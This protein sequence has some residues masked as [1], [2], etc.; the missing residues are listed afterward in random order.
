MPLINKIKD[1]KK[2]Y[3]WSKRASYFIYI[4]LFIVIGSIWFEGFESIATYLGFVSAAIAFALKD[5]IANVAGWMFIT[6]RAPFKIG[7]R[8]ELEN[9]AGDVIDINLFNFSIMEMGNWVDADD[10]TGRIIHIPNARVFTGSLANYGKGFHFIWHEMPVLVTFESD[11]EKA[12]IILDKIIKTESEKFK[13]DASKMIKEAS[14]K[15]MIHKTSLDPIVY[16]TVEDSG[17]ALTIRFLCEPRQRREIEQDIWESI[18][19]NFKNEMDIDFAYPTVR[20]FM[21]K[22]ENKVVISKE[23]KELNGNS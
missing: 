6:T 15:F 19:L 20:R 22:E 21:N 17:V 16:T 12:K 11:W 23:E 7:D 4:F 5:P 8:I 1:T 14:K 2:R 9:N 18:L 10:M 13:I 3:I